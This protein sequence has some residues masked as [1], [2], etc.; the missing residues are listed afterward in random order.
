MRGIMEGR[1]G[2]N[3]GCKQLFNSE[4]G[5]NVTCNRCPWCNGGD[6]VCWVRDRRKETDT[7]DMMRLQIR[8]RPMCFS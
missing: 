6:G 4:P 1:E 3:Q 7:L 8:E 5:D 2:S